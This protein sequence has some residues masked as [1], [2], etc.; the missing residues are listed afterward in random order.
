MDEFVDKNVVSNKN[1]IMIEELNCLQTNEL[2]TKY[3]NEKIEFN[4]NFEKNMLINFSF[5]TSY[6]I[7]DE[8][9]FEFE[10]NEKKAS[11]IT[12]DTQFLTNT[13]VGL[14]N[15]KSSINTMES[16]LNILKNKSNNGLFDLISNDLN[17]KNTNFKEITEFEMNSLILNSNYYFRKNEHFVA[18]E[19]RLENEI[20]KRKHCEKQ[21]F[22]LNENVIKLKEQIALYNCFENRREIFFQNFESIVEKVLQ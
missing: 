6:A 7:H 8:S 17:I 22:E 21:I 10:E 13:N 9:L 14:I 5:N 3:K 16:I 15:F 12:N 2:D 19:N 11:S 20:L 4:S 1:I 18:I